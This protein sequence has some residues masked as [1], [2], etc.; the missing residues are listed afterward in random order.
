MLVALY[1]QVW[2]AS[3]LGK[4]LGLSYHTVNQYADFLEQAFLIRRLPAYSTNIR[5]RLVK[6]PKLYW[7]DSGLLHA[8]LD[9]PSVADIF[10][11]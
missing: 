7:R 11:L 10:L 3:Q 9:L 4:S 5:K 8:L 2:N 1:G 6:S